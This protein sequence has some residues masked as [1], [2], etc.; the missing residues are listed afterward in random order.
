MAKKPEPKEPIAKARLDDE[1]RSRLNRIH[2][3]HKTSDTE[4][5]TELI[6]AFVETV[7]RADAVRFPVTILLAE[8]NLLVAEGGVRTDA[9]KAPASTGEKLLPG[10]FAGGSLPGHTIASAHL[11]DSAVKPKGAK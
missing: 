3:R 7:E 2:Q 6:S 10:T 1:L 11:R 9:T 5:L 8:K 4:I